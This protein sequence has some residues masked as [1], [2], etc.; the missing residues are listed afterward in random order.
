MDVTVHVFTGGMLKFWA[1][2]TGVISN[3]QT[4][5][6][7]NGK[8]FIVTPPSSRSVARLGGLLVSVLSK[9]RHILA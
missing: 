2:K 4:N 6:A 3:P 7:F 8:E 5:A 9:K 1:N